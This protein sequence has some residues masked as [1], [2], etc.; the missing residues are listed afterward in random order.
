[1]LGALDADLARGCPHVDRVDLV[2]EPPAPQGEPVREG[3]ELRVREPAQVIEDA[4]VVPP[5]PGRQASLQ[6]PTDG[7]AGH[8][9]PIVLHHVDPALTRE[10]V[11]RVGALSPAQQVAPAAAREDV[12]PAEPFQ[13]VV[14]FTSVEQ[15]G[16]PLPAPEQIVTAPAVDQA[17]GASVD[18]P[19]L[20]GQLRALDP[21]YP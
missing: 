11:I 2:G 6:H 20:V 16:H 14:A 8:R 1:M 15:V 19:H 3:A 7:R 18:R 10:E 13:R 9:K 12:A 17:R 21:L 5:L 4:L